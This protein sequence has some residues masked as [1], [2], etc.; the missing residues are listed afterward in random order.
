MSLTAA[1]LE[2]A[3]KLPGAAAITEENAADVL[4]GS[5][6]NLK[7]ELDTAQQQ[8]TDAKG[9]IPRVEEPEVLAGRLEIAEGRINLMLEQGKLTTAQAD[10][11]KNSL[12]VDGKPNPAMLAKMGADYVYTPL[13]KTIELNKPNGIVNPLTSAQ[14]RQRETPGDPEGG[15]KE[16]TEE[17]RRELLGHVGIVPSNGNGK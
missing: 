1:Q 5:A 11:M 16:V 10:V 17:K 12:K 15:Q 4:F 6:T 3:R 13:L 2:V 7:T 14:P 9:R 8:L